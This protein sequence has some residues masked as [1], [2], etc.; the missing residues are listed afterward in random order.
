MSRDATTPTDGGGTPGSPLSRLA[1]STLFPGASNWPWIVD[2]TLLPARLYAGVTIAG[3]GLD[4]LP[5]PDWMVDQT[6][7]MGFP[8]PAFFATIACVT[9]FAFG[10]LLAAGLCT[11]LSALMLAV[12]MGFASFRFH[13]L[14]PILDMHI[15]QGF[16][17]LF[18]AFLA[19]GPGRFS[20]DALL[21]R[22]FRQKETGVLKWGPALITAGVLALPAFA[23]AGYREFLYTP[24]PE[25]EQ[26]SSDEL[27]VNSVSLAGTFN[28]WSLETTPMERVET[29][30]GAT[31]WRANVEL[32][33]SG[34]VAFKFA[35][36]GSWDIAVGTESPVIELSAD[37][38]AAGPGSTAGDNIVVVIPEAGT[39]VF[40]IDP[41]SL[42]F[43]VAAAGG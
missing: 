16:V 14:T 11:R 26:A 20:V 24:P 38:P 25:P 39:Y 15:A 19:V 31:A 37:A 41:E 40:E 34:P 13:E 17:W 12:T 8:A 22:G 35:V 9:E 42:A 5:T 32:P 6:A 43:T 28:G 36:N 10:L 21:R 33:A 1:V 23:F 27:N 18:V 29:E 3:A 2:L 7:Q 4:K 30:D